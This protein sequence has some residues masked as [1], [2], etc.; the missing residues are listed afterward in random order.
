MKLC[1]TVPYGP[2]RAGDNFG[3]N[4]LLPILAATVIFRETR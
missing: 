4:L 1:M 3:F 2:S